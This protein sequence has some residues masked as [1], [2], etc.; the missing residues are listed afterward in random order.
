MEGNYRIH[1]I[2]D[3]RFREPLFPVEDQKDSEDDQQ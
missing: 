3:A 1:L 2:C